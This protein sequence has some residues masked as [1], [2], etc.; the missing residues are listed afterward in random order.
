MHSGDSQ[1]LSKLN[2]IDK[3]LVAMSDFVGGE[4]RSVLSLETVKAVLNQAF[5]VRLGSGKELGVS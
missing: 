4:D 1:L 2:R 5:P 3:E